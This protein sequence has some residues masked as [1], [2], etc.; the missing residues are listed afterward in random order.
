MKKKILSLI[1]VAFLCSMLITGCKDDD[2]VAPVVTLVGSADTVIA[3]GST[4]VDPGVLAVDD[5][6]GDI[7]SKVVVSGTP[8]NTAVPG[9]YELTYTSTD[10]A[11]NSNSVVRVVTVSWTGAQL[12]GSYT[13]SDTCI[14]AGTVV[15]DS[16]TSVATA[17]VGNAYRVLFSNLS[18]V[19]T[20]NTYADIVGDELTI[21][22]QSPNGTGSTYT[23]SGSGTIVVSGSNVIWNIS[24]SVQDSQTG[25]NSTC[26]AHF[27]SQ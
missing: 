23:V 3:K 14:I 12:A 19:F 26:T 9:V 20:G 2:A 24:Y 6:D 8:V 10:E 1:G 7:S 22:S 11:G 16:Y 13:V 21:P 18:N 5:Q 25:L 17:S 27:V 4:W 15:P